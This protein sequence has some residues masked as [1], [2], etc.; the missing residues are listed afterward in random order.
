MKKACTALILSVFLLVNGTGLCNYNPLEQRKIVV[1]GFEYEGEGPYGYLG[2]AL[3]KLLISTAS[4]IPFIALTDEERRLLKE[5]SR[6]EEFQKK[7]PGLRGPGGYRLEPLIEEGEPAAGEYPLFIHGSY[8]VFQEGGEGAGSGGVMGKKA[9]EETLSL[10]VRSHNFMTGSSNPDYLIETDL[11]EFLNAPDR[12]LIPF[13]NQLLRYKTYTVSISTDPPDG[14]IFVDHRL[15]GIGNA[16]SLLLTPGY[17]RI[18]VRLKGYEDYSDMVWVSGD[19]FLRQV[20]L[21]KAEGKFRYRAESNV[22]KAEVYIDGTF[23]GPAPLGFAMEE[24][25][26]TLTLIKEGYRS[27]SIPLSGLGSDRGE[28]LLTMVRP[29]EHKSLLGEAEAHRKRSRLLYRAGLGMMGLTI[30]SGVQ[31]TLNRQKADLYRGINE[32]RY[33]AAVQKTTLYTALT[34][35]SLLIGG[36]IFTL[37]F[38][39]ILRYFKLYSDGESLIFR[40]QPMEK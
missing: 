15:A 8:R 34:A 13:I 31:T 12:F 7:F 20:H 40:V 25:D 36:G 10:T 21:K 38:I 16:G 39:Q 28:L 23:A 5:F 9:P 3:Q 35:S 22:E 30:I 37:S 32:E 1:G 11:N 19:G 18:D 29:D 4:R 6:T 27:V 24:P 17:H 26:T 14:I 33:D 2:K